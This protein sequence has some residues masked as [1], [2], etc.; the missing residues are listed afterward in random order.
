M[1]LP[2]RALSST[3]LGVSI[4]SPRQV[5]SR[6]SHRAWCCELA[7]LGCRHLCRQY[8]RPRRGLSC[9]ES[10]PCG[11]KRTKVSRRWR[12]VQRRGSASGLLH[13]WWDRA[14]RFLNG[15]IAQRSLDIIRMSIVFVNAKTASALV[16]SYLRT[17]WSIGVEGLSV[18]DLIDHQIVLRR[19]KSGCHVSGHQE[20]GG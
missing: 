9:Q 6:A 8:Q 16:H 11:S 10:P 7:C 18:F 3:R 13:G 4:L 1:S 15:Y 14:C 17:S 5:L 19:H 20:S 2:Y 12:K